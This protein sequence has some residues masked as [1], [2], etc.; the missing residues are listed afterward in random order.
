LPKKQTIAELLV[1]TDADKTQENTIEKFKIRVAY[2]IST[3]VTWNAAISSLCGRTLEE[4]FGL[5]NAVWSQ[6][7]GNRH[8]GLKLNQMPT[9]P[10]ELAAGLHKKVTGRSF[11]K[12][13]FALGVLTEPPENWIVPKYIKE[14]LQW[15][16][17]EVCVELQPPS[18]AETQNENMETAE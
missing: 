9:T 3:P 6:V 14:G 17:E 11:D 15:L 16:A 18:Q 8:I 1:A 4:S 5:E 12:T 2:Q 13:K 7:A 10:G